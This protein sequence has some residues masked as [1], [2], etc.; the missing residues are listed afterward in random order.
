MA[1]CKDLLLAPMMSKVAKLQGPSFRSL[2]A[3]STSSIPRILLVTCVRLGSSCILYYDTKGKRNLPQL[4]QRNDSFP[5][6]LTLPMQGTSHPWQKSKWNKDLKPKREWEDGLY[7]PGWGHRYDWRLARQT[8][9]SAFKYTVRTRAFI[10][11]Y[12]PVLYAKRWT[13]T[14]LVN[15]IYYE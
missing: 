7:R 5:F 6:I 1:T 10:P 4:D 12:L 2:R 14:S 9:H 3:N 15:F 11:V 8:R 13:P